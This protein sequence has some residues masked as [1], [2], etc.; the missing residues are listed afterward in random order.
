MKR[1]PRGKPCCTKALEAMDSA[2]METWFLLA[3][4]VMDN[5]REERERMGQI[6]KPK[7]SG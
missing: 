5:T 1:F 6:R 7:L 4:A 2:E 3:R